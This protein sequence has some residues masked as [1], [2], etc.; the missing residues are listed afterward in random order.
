V[1]VRRVLGGDHDRDRPLAPGI[2][3]EE[4]P[5]VGTERLAEPGCRGDREGGVALGRAREPLGQETS[6]GLFDRPKRRVGT[7][8]ANV[9]GDEAPVGFNLR[10]K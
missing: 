3:V 6:P 1:G 7:T 8:S 10:L 4:C 5:L 9:A 2:R